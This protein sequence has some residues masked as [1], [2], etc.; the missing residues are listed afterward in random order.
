MARKQQISRDASY[1]LKQDW[2]FE[3]WVE[4]DED[5]YNALTSSVVPVDTSVLRALKQSPLALDLHGWATY[6]AFA[7]TKL[8]NRTSR[9]SMT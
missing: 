7:P 3:S 5:F 9:V 1:A 8:A 4:F 6:K 2:Q